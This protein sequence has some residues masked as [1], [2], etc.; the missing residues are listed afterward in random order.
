MIDAELLRIGEKHAFENIKLSMTYG[1]W[2]PAGM[3]ISYFISAVLGLVF[4]STFIYDRKQKL[5]LLLNEERHIVA[6]RKESFGFIWSKNVKETACSRVL[7]AD[8]HIPTLNHFL[9][10]GD[11]S[12][13]FLTNTNAGVFTD[14]V[15]ITG[16]ADP[17][18]AKEK[19]LA[20]S[21]P[22]MGLQVR[23]V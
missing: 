8:I 15:M 6:I 21:A 12:I 14:E 16:I 20:A 23:T 13:K 22:D 19:I 4:L 1:F 9:N 11:L 7:K 17:G 3:M 18:D 2:L 5:T 10:A